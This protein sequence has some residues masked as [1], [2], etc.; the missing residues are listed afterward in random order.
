MLPK[1]YSGDAIGS[2]HCA[3]LTAVKRITVVVKSYRCYDVQNWYFVWNGFSFTILFFTFHIRRRRERHLIKAQSVY[4]LYRH[5]III[6]SFSE[7]GRHCILS[8]LYTST[9]QPDR[10]TYKV[11]TISRFQ[12]VISGER[13]PFLSERIVDNWK[14]KTKTQ[15]QTQEIINRRIIKNTVINNW[16][17]R[18][19]CLIKSVHFLRET[20]VLLPRIRNIHIISYLRFGPR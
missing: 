6:L 5:I 9:S 11:L 7:I 17:F 16:I 13:Y 3:W 15:T 20:T 2:I 10:P 4:Y 19:V 1:I 12:F 18:T 14:N 8:R